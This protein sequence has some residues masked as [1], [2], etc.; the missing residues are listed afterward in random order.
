MSQKN[1][2]N[3]AASTRQKLLNKARKDQRPFAELLQYFAM[4]RFLYRLSQ[5]K[6]KDKFI[7][8][9]A[10]AL[11]AW[12]A[13]TVRPTKDI[14]LLGEFDNDVEVITQVIS[15]ICK[16]DIEPDDGLT[17]DMK[18][19]TGIK[20]KEDADYQGVRVRFLSFLDTAKVTMQIDIGF[21]DSVYPKPKINTYP[22]LLD[23]PAS[24]L[25]SYSKETTIAEKLEAMV[26]LGELNSRMKDFYDIWLLSRQFPFDGIDLQKSIIGT[27]SQRG[28]EL[29]SEIEAFTEGF[30]KVKDVQWKAFRNNINNESI[31]LNFEVIT[32]QIK[33]FIQPIIGSTINES[34]YDKNWLPE[35]GWG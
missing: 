33:S 11:L 20:I 12:N 28:T 13:P 16:Q 2:K 23:F 15:E 31:P 32:D 17:F 1:I 9:G 19:I 25:L 30:A 27:F 21:G 18:T 29:S 7:L 5:S 35:S 34:D 8:K 10:L 4:E 24:K 3:I 14:D 22:T 6:Y 26:K